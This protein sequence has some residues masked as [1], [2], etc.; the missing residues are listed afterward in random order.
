M[1]GRGERPVSRKIQLAAL[2]V[3]SCFQTLN[4][5]AAPHL[6][7]VPVQERASF[8]IFKRNLP[9]RVQNT[10]RQLAHGVKNMH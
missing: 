6:H 4:L 2:T 10:V 3:P 5:K 7:I 8:A 9:Y 1:V